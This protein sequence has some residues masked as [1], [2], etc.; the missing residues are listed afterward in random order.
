MGKSLLV[1]AGWTTTTVASTTHYY[2][3]GN[4]AL[5]FHTTEGHRQVKFREAGVLSHL[6][7]EISANSTTG[8]STCRTR[9]NTANGNM[10]VSISA[11]ATGVFEDTV[12]TDT[13]AVNDV[14]NYQTVTGAGGTFNIIQMSTIFTPTA[15]SVTY[16]PFCNVNP[17]TLALATASVTRHLHLG[18]QMYLGATTENHLQVEMKLAGVLHSM[19]V[20]IAANTRSGAVTFRTRKNGANGNLVV[21]VTGGGTG[22]FEDLTNTDTV[23]VDEEWNLSITTATGTGSVQPQMVKVDFETASD[24]GLLMSN[25]VFG[26][27][28][29]AGF[30]QYSFLGGTLVPNGNETNAPLKLRQ[31]FTFSKLASR[32]QANTSNGTSRVRLRVNNAFGN[33]DI[34]IATTATGWFEDAV[35]T[36]VCVATDEVNFYATSPAG[37]GSMNYRSISM[38]ST[39]QSLQNLT[40]TIGETMTLSH[41]TVDLRGLNQTVSHD[42]AI[43]HTTND[44]RGLLQLASHTTDISHTTND[45]RGLVQTSSD[46][47]TLESTVPQVRNKVRAIAEALSI[48]K[49]VEKFTTRLRTISHDSTISHG[50]ITGLRG[51]LHVFSDSLTLSGTFSWLSTRIRT[52][53]ENIDLTAPI[54]KFTNKNRDVDHTVTLEHTGPTRLRGLAR[55]LSET[56][57]LSD[58]FNW[59][60][61]RIRTISESLDISHLINKY[62]NRNTDFEEEMTLEH[63]AVKAMEARV[64]LIAH[65]LGITEAISRLKA[66]NRTIDEDEL[67]LTDESSRVRGK[68]GIIDEE[69]QWT[70]TIEKMSTRLRGFSSTM[71]LSHLFTNGS[72][73]IKEIFETME[74]TDSVSRLRGMTRSISDGVHDVGLS[75]SI[76]RLQ[77]KM[78]IIEQSLELGDSNQTLLTRIRGFL[79]DISFSHAI[80][81]SRGSVLR[82][83][84]HTLELA[85]E[86]IK[87]TTRL[88]TISHDLGLSENISRI[89][90][91]LKIIEQELV[92]EDLAEQ[93]K[94]KLAI[95]SNS[96]LLSDAYIRTL[97][98]LRTVSE[99]LSLTSGAT[100]LTTRLRLIS[101]DLSLTDSFIQSVLSSLVKTISHELTLED[102]ISKAK[103]QFRSFTHNLDLSSGAV[104]SRLLVIKTLS[105]VL[106]LSSTGTRMRLFI[107]RNISHS[108]TL[109]STAVKTA[110]S[111]VKMFA[112]KIRK[113]KL[114]R[115]S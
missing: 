73:K 60:S 42:T 10:S 91:K 106:N 79:E 44:L 39:Y 40:R 61:T 11:G 88:R 85:H 71:T 75:E 62:R 90:T 53:S 104:R 107:I 105:H 51:L 24:D 87:S 4:S 100:R 114:Y 66:I 30:V 108:L 86:N 16:T 94:L 12:N 59:L 58:S 70:K 46:T 111:A 113:F 17:S 33:Q 21:S 32:V 37:T 22:T 52:I 109:S 34:S 45:L 82:T 41:T 68:I 115:Y 81:N 80:E 14:L 1:T 96:L 65:A 98:R 36:D 13:V 110:K 3:L 7:I 57:T 50:N 20:K 77:Q 43:S 55:I 112:L 27:D 8:S 76:N 95:V 6:L 64:R 9:K 18:G 84:Q 99:S 29:T 28:T 92:L 67:E 25:Y 49:T 72:A 83:I 47:M 69:F 103:G 19:S 2:A 48:T 35:N 74:L 5:T 54:N 78:R 26:S 15:S 93:I 31:P 102:S 38:V 97:S 63:G 23:S 56:I 101:Q 89:K